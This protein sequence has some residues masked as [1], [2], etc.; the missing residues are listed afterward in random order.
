MDGAAIA[1]EIRA[2]VAALVPGAGA[3]AMY[4]GTMFELVPGDFST[5]F[6][7]VFVYRAHV[8][9]EFG[10]GAQLDDPLGVLE[11]K[12]RARRHVKLRCLGDIADKGVRDYLVRAAAALAEGRA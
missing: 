5:A 10:R 8:S 4:G 2:L 11:G 3:R 6:A 7:G 1:A 9:V 12:G